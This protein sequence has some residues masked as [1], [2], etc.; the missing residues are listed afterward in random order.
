MANRIKEIR[1][2]KGMT[3]EELSERS[4]VSRVMISLLETD[5]ERTTTTTTL[6]KLARALGVTVDEIFFE[7]T[8]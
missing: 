7:T 3:Q 2:S 1:K 8:V 5:Q 6:L 4:G